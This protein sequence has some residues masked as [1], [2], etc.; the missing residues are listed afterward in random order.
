M[1]LYYQF[2]QNMEFPLKNLPVARSFPQEELAVLALEGMESPSYD[3]L[4]QLAERIL[5]QHRG[6][7]LI[8]A[9]QQDMAKALGQLLALKLG[10]EAKILCIDRVRLEEGSFLDVG[11]P[12]GPALPV[13]V[14][15]LVLSNS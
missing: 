14:K 6:G 10:K 12:V 8:L 11:A 15:T 3:Q 5:E 2:Y 4:R 1:P 9:I 13:V 7:M